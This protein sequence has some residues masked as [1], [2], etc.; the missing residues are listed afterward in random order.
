LE[1]LALDFQEAILMANT[2]RGSE[3]L[4]WLDRADRKLI[5]L[6]GLNPLKDQLSGYCGFKT[7]TQ[8]WLRD[9]A[10]DFRWIV[11]G[12]LSG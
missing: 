9:F 4:T 8:F 10:S 1:N 3:R 12:G 7:E 6:L 5:C 2:V 11:E